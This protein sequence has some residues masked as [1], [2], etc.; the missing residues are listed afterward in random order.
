M[1]RE[2]ACGDCT[3]LGDYSPHSLHS[4]LWSS[5]HVGVQ[6]CSLSNQGSKFT[7]AYTKKK[8]TCSLC[9]R[10]CL[11]YRVRVGFKD[12]GPGKISRSKLLHAVV[13]TNICL[14]VNHDPAFDD[15]TFCD[16]TPKTR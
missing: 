8:N 11:S 6:G 13:Q 3:K 5:L 16:R 15:P 10:I 14:V 1:W 2:T 9:R 7:S 4:S 12:P